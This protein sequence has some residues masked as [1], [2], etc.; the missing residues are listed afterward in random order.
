MNQSTLT[1]ESFPV[2][3]FEAE[4]NPA[5]SDPLEFASVAFLKQ[6]IAQE[7]GTGCF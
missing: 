2:E 6:F 3:K 5:A 4:K 1:G 7:A